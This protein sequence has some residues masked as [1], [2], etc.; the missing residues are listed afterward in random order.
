[1]P[2]RSTKLFTLTALYDATGKL[3]EDKEDNFHGDAVV[4][5][6]DF[7]TTVSKAIPE[8][9]QVKNGHLRSIDLRQEKICAHSV[10]LRP[11]GAVGNQA[12]KESPTDWKSV[13][14]DLT[15]INW[16]KEI[17]DW[18]NVCIIANSVVSNRQAR[19]ATRSYLKTSSAL[20]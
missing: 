11:I 9:M 2:V 3:L 5:A 19:V 15:E 18:E 13:I 6:V 8:W 20:N 17:P 1:L 4:K 10:V 7:W 16:K 12:M 14:L